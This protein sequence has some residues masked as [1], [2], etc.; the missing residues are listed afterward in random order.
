MCRISDVLTVSIQIRISYHVPLATCAPDIGKCC[1]TGQ[2]TGHSSHLL[3]V[4]LAGG[5]APTRAIHP[6]ARH[7][8]IWWTGTQLRLPYHTIPEYTEPEI[9]A[10]EYRAHKDKSFF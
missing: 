6:L 7:P 5:T 4:N 9:H 10:K 3:L 2:P 1:Y 8:L